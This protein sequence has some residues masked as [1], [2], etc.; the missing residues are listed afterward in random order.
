M[1]WNCGDDGI[2]A[3]IDRLLKD[4]VSCEEYQEVEREKKELEE[5][6]GKSEREIEE[7]EE[8]IEELEET[9]CHID[10][11]GYPSGLDWNPGRE[12]FVC[13]Q[14][15]R[16]FKLVESDELVTQNAWFS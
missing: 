14:T 3:E 4:Y 9:G 6:L 11:P 12:L 2:Q 16:T 5:Q 13:P 10:M 1:S 15:G 7:L 8:K